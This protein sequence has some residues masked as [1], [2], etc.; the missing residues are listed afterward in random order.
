LASLI[1]TNDFARAHNC[2]VIEQPAV[3]G[4]CWKDTFGDWHRCMLCGAMDWRRNVL[5]PEGY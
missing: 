5:P 2:W 3:K 1:A 4:Y